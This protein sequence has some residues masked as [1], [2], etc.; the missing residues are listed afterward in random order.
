MIIMSVG[1]VHIFYSTVFEY[2]ASPYYALGVVSIGGNLMWS[3]YGIFCLS[4]VVVY[5]CE[6][7]ESEVSIYILPVIYVI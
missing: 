5:P 4:V 7:V 3:M 1:T 2:Q 6:K